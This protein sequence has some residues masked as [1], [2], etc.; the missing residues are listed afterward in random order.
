MGFV[1]NCQKIHSMTDSVRVWQEP[2]TIPTYGIGSPEK[3]PM[4]MEKRV[5]QG[6]SG[7]VYPYPV[8]E[9]IL[10][11]KSDKTYNGLFLE[12]RYLK[13]MILPEL[14]GRIQ[15]AFDKMKQRH[16]IYYNSVI[17]PALVGLTGPW[18]SGGIEFNWPQHH[19]PSTFEPID[20]SL[21]ENPDGSCTVWVNEIEK[22][23]HTRA[24]V[25]FTLHPGK[26]YIEISA[27]LFNP[28]PFPQ[29]FLWW[30]N[31]AVKVND[32]YQSVFPP[33]VHAVFDHGKRDVSEFPI[34][35][36]EYYKVNYAPGTDIS[37]YRNI[38]VP[39]S[40]M[41]V[42]S[43]YDFVGGYENDTRGGLLHV[44]DHHVSPGKKQW[45]WGNGEFGQ[46]WDRHLTDEDG[47]YIE[48]MTG[49]F[50]DNQPDF[51]WLQPNEEKSFTQYFMPY[52]E[53]GM[54]KN[55]TKDI[56]IGMEAGNGSGVLKLYAT[57]EFADL[58]LS[59]TRLSDGKV[60]YSETVSC[61]PESPVIRLVPD[62]KDIAPEDLLYEV[63]ENATGK[64]LVSYREESP[65]GKPVPEPARRPATP[66]ETATHEELYLTGLHLEQ[67]RHATY[68]ASDYYE[69]ALRRDPS[70]IRCN[71]AQGLL[72][73]RR[74]MPAK[75][76][77]HF[78]TAVESLTRRNPNPYDGEPY[79]NLGWCLMLQE[80]FGEA[81]D[82]FYKSTWNQAWKHA[83]SL[84]LARIASMRG[85]LA[86]A[87]MHTDNS[88][89][90][91]WHSPSARH[92]KTALLRRSGRLEEALAFAGSTLETD[93][94][95]FGCLFERYLILRDVQAP[96]AGEA[97]TH[98]Q[99]LLRGRVENY[100]ETAM[101]Y[102]HAG[103]N[104]EALELLT[105]YTHSPGT[106]YPMALYTMGWVSLR[107]G[108]L[109]E[110][111]GWFKKA[112][113][114]PPDFCFP[115]RVEDVLI[116]NAAIRLNPAD[117]RAPWYLGNL[118]YD[119]RQYDEAIGFWEMSRSL[120]P[121]FPTVHRN[122]A[123]AYFNKRQEPQQALES[124][125]TAFRLDSRDARVLMELDQLKKKLNHAPVE[126]LELLEKHITL[127]MQRDDLYLERVTLLNQ[128]G[129]F[130]RAKELLAVWKF[131]PWEGGE[132]KVVAQHL[133]CHIE[134]AKDATDA[135]NYGE[136]IELLQIAG[137]YP[138][139]LGEGK[140]P[141]A[142]ENDI[143]YLMGVAHEK[144]GNPAEAERFFR[145]AVTGISEPVQ[146]IFYN[147]PQP[148]KI[149]YQG[150]GWLKLREPEK[151]QATFDRLTGFGMQH[152]ND[153]I[154][155]DY[156][157]VSLP[158]MQVFDTDL[159]LRNR[160]H[161]LYLQALGELGKGGEA[162]R[163]ASEDLFREVI[164][165][166]INHQGALVQLRRL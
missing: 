98:L 126:R 116:L 105:L 62:C 52:A 29:T 159:D 110:A 56:I 49:V 165:L 6:S 63:M 84:N 79:Y 75:A 13:I 123:L 120:D 77:P 10:D 23:F 24:T 121:T 54:V 47:P 35:R 11:E 89:I 82:A 30:A 137:N 19:R 143:H 115:N 160:I 70:D 55:A 152:M 132:G 125:N 163:K 119:K 118:F 15:M 2:V 37:R 68:T 150:L 139:N 28:T 38:P 73:L 147:D 138:V 101:D 113:A 112:S 50:T 140:L 88:L 31:P 64:K 83:G 33:D 108:R 114:C 91:Q 129:E 3:N 166:D 154:R 134:L 36:G 142:Q 135:G 7:V 146:A 18:I 90:N 20:W 48:L 92:L 107:K 12:N 58:R 14:G 87:L 21:S 149:F 128:V 164:N 1:G 22:M 96:E 65:A 8:I 67:Y 76:E 103:L 99:S 93:R 102:A 69:E 66:A 106:V 59:L 145:Q 51:S 94:F 25:G 9:K 111:A 86:G 44:A 127:V 122:L 43:A 144:M 27:R 130:R 158:D 72:L 148:D 157:A 32:D 133:W 41:A 95:N 81:Y 136:A 53:V 40:Y 141:T 104:D 74:G 16:F 42:S 5:Y 155:L 161:C 117:A 45:T 153:T 71:N 156:F 109:D 46:A 34:A 57:G 4:F 78:R 131:H 26:A 80:R 124:L 100:L 61:S 97:L 39:T 151:A 162:G 85:D 17:K 60:M